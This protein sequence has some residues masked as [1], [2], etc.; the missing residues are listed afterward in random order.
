MQYIQPL[1]GGHFGFFLIDCL[2]HSKQHSQK[3]ILRGGGGE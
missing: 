1:N 2:F 3:N